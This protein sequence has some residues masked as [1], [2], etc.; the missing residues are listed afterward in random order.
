MEYEPHYRL[1]AMNHAIDWLSKTD[2]GLKTPEDVVRLETN[3]P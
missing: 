2:P 1:V 3:V